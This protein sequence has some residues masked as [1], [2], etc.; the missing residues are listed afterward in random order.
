MQSTF[1]QKVMLSIIAGAALAGVVEWYKTFV[2]GADDALNGGRKNK[3]S[4]QQKH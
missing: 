3:Y 4:I 2:S 1:I